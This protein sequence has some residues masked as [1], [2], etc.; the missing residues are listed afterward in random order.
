M[1]DWFILFA[2][3]HSKGARKKPW[4]HGSRATIR[5][6]IRQPS[7]GSFKEVSASD[8]DKG[9]SPQRSVGSRLRDE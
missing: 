2:R 9:S 8:L 6:T 1:V 4:Q 5:P 3:R 7:S